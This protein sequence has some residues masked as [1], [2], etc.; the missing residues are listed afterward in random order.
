MVGVRVLRREGRKQRG[1][2]LLPQRGLAGREVGQVGRAGRD[3]ALVVVEHP[4]PAMA[5]HPAE[6]RV[7]ELRVV[8]AVQGPFRQDERPERKLGVEAVQQSEVRVRG[9]E[10]GAHPVHVGVAG[11]ERRRGV[12]RDVGAARVLGYP[13]K[14]DLGLG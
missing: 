13:Q 8:A 10:V 12:G 9:V 11:E 3:E 1:R 5:V 7:H 2:Q 4:H 14:R 6:Q